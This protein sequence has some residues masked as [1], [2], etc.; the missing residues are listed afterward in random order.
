MRIGEFVKQYILSILAHCDEID[1]NELQNI[2]DPG[3]SKVAFG[4]N[5]PF[6]A[7]VERIEQ[8]ESKRYWTQVYVVRGQGIRV[9]SQW[10]VGHLDKFRKYLESK[11]IVTTSISPP[12]DAPKDSAVAHQQKS[13]SRSNSRYR[14]NAIGNAQNLFI[15]NILSNL[16]QE[17]FSESD[18]AATKNYFEHRCAY[19][20]VQ[21]ELVI[22][23]AIPINKEELGEHR[24]GNLVPS[25]KACNNGKAGKDFREFLGENAAAISKIEK[26]MDSSNYVP[27]ESNEQM[28]LILNMA[29]K[30]V[31]ALAERYITIINELFPQ[32]GEIGNQ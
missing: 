8:S 11:H 18:W 20:G 31:A 2:L 13:Q 27:L 5:F 12:C 25:C 32:S 4:L 1:H 7:Q 14:G 16:G 23:H 15:R 17:S 19:C 30:E 9:T 3:Y 29:H 21:G 10:Y 6:C 26:Y 22:E 28:K 24:L